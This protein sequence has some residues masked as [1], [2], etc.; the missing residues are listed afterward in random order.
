MIAFMIW[1]LQWSDGEPKSCPVYEG[2]GISI[3]DLS[4]KAWRVPEDPLVFLSM[5][6]ARSWVPMQVKD[7]NNEPARV[8]AFTNKEQR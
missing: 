8:D 3:P 2:R 6:A 5:L 7:N 4:F 1:A